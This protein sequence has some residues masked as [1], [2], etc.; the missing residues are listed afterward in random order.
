M[1]IC[2]ARSH[3]RVHA[4]AA[5][6]GEIV[7]IKLLDTLGTFVCAARDGTLKLWKPAASAVSS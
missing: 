5:A 1:A 6:D 2:K 7:A 3:E 4:F